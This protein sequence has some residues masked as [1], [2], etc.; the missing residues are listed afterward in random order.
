MPHQPRPSVANGCSLGR[1]VPATDLRLDGGVS[2]FDGPE[3]DHVPDSGPSAK[4]PDP[5]TSGIRR[6]FHLPHSEVKRFRFTGSRNHDVSD[7][8]QSRRHIPCAVHR[9]PRRIT[10]SRTAHG[11]CLLLLSDTSTMCVGGLTETDHYHER[12]RCLARPPA[13]IRRRLQRAREEAQISPV[14]MGIRSGQIGAI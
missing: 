8:S 3:Q 13:S 14:T 2:V 6:T 11:V 1:G 5:A 9:I 12:T 4:P 10:V 7:R